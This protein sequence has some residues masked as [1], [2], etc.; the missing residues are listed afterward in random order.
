MIITCSGSFEIESSSNVDND[1][2]DGDD[3]GNLKIYDDENEFK[4]TLHHHY[5]IHYIVQYVK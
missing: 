4:K 3:D 1:G 5:N 2:N